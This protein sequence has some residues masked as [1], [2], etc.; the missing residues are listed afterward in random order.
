MTMD[1]DRKMTNNEE[2]ISDTKIK[3]S[4]VCLFSLSISHN[5]GLNARPCALAAFHRMLAFRQWRGK[6]TSRSWATNFHVAN[7][8]AV[9]FLCYFRITSIR[10]NVTQW[11]REPVSKAVSGTLK[12]LNIQDMFTRNVLS[13]IKMNSYSPLWPV[14]KMCKILGMKIG[15]KIGVKI[16]SP[17]CQ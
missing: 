17:R 12:L 15:V 13:V 8:I 6:N 9:S 2:K 7:E 5:A 11:V 3:I 4:N 16:L 1:A 14:K 10:W